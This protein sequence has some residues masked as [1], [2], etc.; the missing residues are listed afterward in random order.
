MQHHADYTLPILGAVGTA[1]SETTGQPY[2]LSCT[3]GGLTAAYVA[4]K[5]VLLIRHE[6]KGRNDDEKLD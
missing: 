4:A 2:W 6:L 3:I 5:L 1:V